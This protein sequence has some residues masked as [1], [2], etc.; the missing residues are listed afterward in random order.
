MTPYLN[1]NPFTGY[2]GSAVIFE[3]SGH[4]YSGGAK[5]KH[6]A[7]FA[8]NVNDGLDGD[9]TYFTEKLLPLCAAASTAL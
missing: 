6:L 5:T 3:A 8:P 1:A 9:S 7:D 2:S 4:K